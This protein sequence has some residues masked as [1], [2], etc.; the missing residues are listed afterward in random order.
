MARG[1]MPAFMGV[2]SDYDCPQHMHP[3]RSCRRQ[4]FTSI[5]GLYELVATEF[6]VCAAPSKSIS[7]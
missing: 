7:P 5:R 6:A 1:S 2:L 3:D 4:R